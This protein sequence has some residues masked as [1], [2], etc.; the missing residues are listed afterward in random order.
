MFALKA[1]HPLD[2]VYVPAKIA[3]TVKA[4]YYECSD[5]MRML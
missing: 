2:A 3:V 4:S 5:I 1:D